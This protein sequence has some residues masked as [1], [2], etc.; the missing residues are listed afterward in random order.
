[1]YGRALI[2][3]IVLYLVLFV[4]VAAGWRGFEGEGDE[5]GGPLPQMIGL[6]LMLLAIWHV[7]LNFLHLPRRW[8]PE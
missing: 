8:R 3:G 2:F 4:A 6:Y 1:M 7:V 5:F